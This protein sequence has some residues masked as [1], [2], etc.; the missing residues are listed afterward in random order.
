MVAVFHSDG[1]ITKAAGIEKAIARP[2]AANPRLAGQLVLHDRQ[3]RRTSRRTATRR[4]PTIY[5]AGTPDFSV[6]QLHQADARGAQ[7]GDARR[8]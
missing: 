3:Q 2:Q 6:D 7:G 8:A 4:S 5:P 1:D